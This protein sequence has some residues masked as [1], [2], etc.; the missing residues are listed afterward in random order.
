MSVLTA[1]ASAYES[2]NP[3]AVVAAARESFSATLMST[4]FASFVPNIDAE[5]LPL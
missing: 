1:V 4:D 2:S 3:E 5:L